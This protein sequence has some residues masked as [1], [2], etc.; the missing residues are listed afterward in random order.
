MQ[1]ET[2]SKIFPRL[3]ISA[4]FGKYVSI[5]VKLKI[6]PP[7]AKVIFIHKGSKKVMT[8]T[9]RQKVLYFC[10]GFPRKLYC[11]DLRFLDQRKDKV[12]T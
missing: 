6:R 4:K 9:K 3:L 5:D 10:Y 8:G 12:G 2:D 11:L 7:F 1:S